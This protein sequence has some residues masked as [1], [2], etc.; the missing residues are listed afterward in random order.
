MNNENL[1]LETSE[2][3]RLLGKKIQIWRKYR[4]LTQG[5]L[6]EIT[7]IQRSQIS[8]IEKGKANFSVITLVRIS[9]GLD[10]IF[11]DLLLKYPE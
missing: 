8:R 5:K 4:N 9:A 2:V 11:T 3:L 10:T 7:G 6:A 1:E